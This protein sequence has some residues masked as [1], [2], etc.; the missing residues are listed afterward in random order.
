MLEVFPRFERGRHESIAIPGTY[1]TTPLVKKSSSVWS[2]FVDLVEDHTVL[3]PG[4]T[5]L[6]ISPATESSNPP[7]NR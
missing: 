4:G 6:V 5:V 2:K 1:L 7:H 3:S